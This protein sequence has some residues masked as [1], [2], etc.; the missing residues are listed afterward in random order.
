MR[1]AR[2]TLIL[3]TAVAAFVTQGC[4]TLGKLHQEAGIDVGHNFGGEPLRKNG[5]TQLVG[6]LGYVAGESG[7]DYP[8]WDFGGTGYLML[9]DPMRPGIKAIARRRF[10]RDVALDFS[11]GPMITY[12][13]SAW[14]NGFI[15]GVALNYKFL[16]LRS[17]YMAWPF[18][19]WDDVHSAGD[20]Y[21]SYH[22]PG[23]HE[24]VW[25]NGLTI[26]GNASWIV[27][28]VVTGLIIIAAAGG[29][30]E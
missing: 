25:Y 20:P 19:P 2:P 8:R 12:D 6:E 16:T 30:F 24:H 11:A 15:G 29:A 23:G 9:S 3:V 27:V 21:S 28:G 10:S 14:F 26:N 5:A 18:E 17:G 4:S 7:T 1:L 13:S 22:H